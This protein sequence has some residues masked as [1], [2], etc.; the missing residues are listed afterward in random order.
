MGEE[1]SLNTRREAK[2]DFSRNRGHP[3]FR[4]RMRLLPYAFQKSRACRVPRRGWLGD[5]IY[6]CSLICPRRRMTFSVTWW[7]VHSL[8]RRE[9]PLSPPVLQVQHIHIQS[10]YTL[11]THSCIY[12]ACNSRP[13]AQTRA[14]RGEECDGGEEE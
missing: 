1:I 13:S 5:M 11:Y 8:H 12:K 14:F 3:V 7:L 9:W 4:S 6:E 2:S 10:P